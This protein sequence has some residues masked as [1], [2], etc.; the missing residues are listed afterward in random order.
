MNRKGT[1]V[2]YF[3]PKCY[4]TVYIVSDDND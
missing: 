4:K 2:C 3:E 1:E